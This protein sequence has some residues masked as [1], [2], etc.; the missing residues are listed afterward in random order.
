MNKRYFENFFLS[1]VILLLKFSKFISFIIELYRKYSK[2]DLSKFYLEYL[3]NAKY[4]S[5][6]ISL[7]YLTF[8]KEKDY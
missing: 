4:N 2:I 1:N 8:Y 6:G 3:Y 7:R 5:Q